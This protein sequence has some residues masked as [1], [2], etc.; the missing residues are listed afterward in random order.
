VDAAKHQNNPQ[1]SYI[2]MMF[3]NTLPVKRITSG[4][5]IR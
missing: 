3:D 1:D 2:F 4:C 5:L